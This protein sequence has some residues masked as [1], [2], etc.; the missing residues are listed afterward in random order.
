MHHNRSRA[1]LNAKWG[2]ILKKSIADI[3]GKKK[4]DRKKERKEKRR[5]GSW[6]TFSN[7]Q[8]C[9]L[10]SSSSGEAPL[11]FLCHLGWCLDSLPQGYGQWTM[12]SFQGLQKGKRSLP[13]TAPCPSSYLCAIS[14]L[15]ATPGEKVLV[16]AW[17][18]QDLVFLPS[19]S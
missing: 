17:H 19:L 10:G 4:K 7:F 14:C 15:W 18:S 11:H 2:W 1:N 8:G 9:F 16:L 3:V 13:D 12:P 5:F 6:N